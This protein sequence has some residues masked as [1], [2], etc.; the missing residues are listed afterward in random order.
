[1]MSAVIDEGGDAVKFALS[2][3]GRHWWKGNLHSHTTISDGRAEPAAMVEHYRDAGWNFL[4]ITDHRTFGFHESLQGDAFLVLPGLEGDINP[5]VGTHHV[6]ALGDASWREKHGRPYQSPQAGEN[7]GQALL[8]SLGAEQA[9]TMY[10]HPVWSRREFADIENLQGFSLFEIYNHG[11][12]YG[13]RTGLAVLY[14]DSLLRRGRKVWGTAVDDSHSMEGDSLGG[15]VMVRS[16][17]LTTDGVLAALRA[18]HFYSSAGPEI[19][20]WAVDGDEVYVQCSPVCS[21]HFV[22]WEP[23]GRSVHAE[24]GQRLTEAVYRR[25]GG[26]GFVRVECVDSKGRTAWSNPIFFAEA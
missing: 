13:N 8:D 17:H 4:A 18:G 9:L 6:V 1:M 12:E 21:I 16:D 5:D 3:V 7:V 25:R 20:E 10:C 24:P 26:E 23:H 11:C 22:A 14:W 15:W 19:L 2:E